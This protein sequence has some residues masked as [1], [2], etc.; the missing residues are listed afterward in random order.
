VIN[1]E[2]GP[3]PQHRRGDDYENRS[4][5]DAV[6]HWSVMEG[7]AALTLPYGG[8]ESADRRNG[9]SRAIPTRHAGLPVLRLDDRVRTAVFV[10]EQGCSY[11]H[12]RAAGTT[13]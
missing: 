6:A 1:D 11:P 12:S 3:V 2:P 10:S 5:P 8:D 7:K 4:I 13:R 9:S